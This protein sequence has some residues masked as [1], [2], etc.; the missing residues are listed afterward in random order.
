MKAKQEKIFDPYPHHDDSKFFGIIVKVL[1]RLTFKNTE[2]TDFGLMKVIHLDLPT[3]VMCL[4]PSSHNGQHCNVIKRGHYERIHCYDLDFPFYL[5][6]PKFSCNG[7]SFSALNEK[8]I[9]S[10]PFS[11]DIKLELVVMGKN[12]IVLLLFVLILLY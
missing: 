6:H 9:K 2:S 8:F 4:N 3:P 1:L 11:M 5:Q 7:N 12:I 10:I